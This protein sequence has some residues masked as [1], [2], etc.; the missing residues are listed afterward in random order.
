MLNSHPATV[1]GVLP[2]TLDFASVF[3]PGTQMDLFV[4]LPLT[5]RSNAWGNNLTLIGRLK[6]SVNLAK[7]AAEMTVLGAGNPPYRSQKRQGGRIGGQ[8]DCGVSRFARGH[9]GQRVHAPTSYPHAILAC[10]ASVEPLT[11]GLDEIE[12]VDAAS[13][14]AARDERRCGLNSL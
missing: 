4:P 9:G 13:R 11:L 5:K 1:V 3:D 7:A 2:R 8:Q 6:P 10:C 14:L 12:R